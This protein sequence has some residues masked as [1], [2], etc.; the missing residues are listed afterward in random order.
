MEVVKEDGAYYLYYKLTAKPNAKTD[1]I[2]LTD[3][4]G[5][6]QTVTGNIEVKV[7]GQD[8]AHTLSVSDGGRVISG[9]ITPA[10]GI[11]ANKEVV[12]T[13]KVKL[14]QNEDGTPKLTD[15][16][17]HAEWQWDDK[18]WEDETEVTP[19]VPDP[20][21]GVNKTAPSS[22]K[23][24]EGIEY[25]VTI[26]NVEVEPDV[27]A[28]LHNYTFH[29]YISNYPFAFNGPVTVKDNKNIEVSGGSIVRPVKPDGA[30]PGE[31]F[32]LF[33]YTFPENSTAPYY[34]ITYTVTAMQET[35]RL[36]NLDVFSS[37]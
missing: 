23:P 10:G 29:D 7:D 26:H 28:D 36:T 37:T 20:A 13:Y 32:E 35:L 14:D 34:T 15:K 17:N 21:F 25:T 31:S 4:I 30:Q 3:T 2:H 16:T 22:V 19:E 33:N 1:S 18:P 9:D 8:A 5:E 6:G 12:V 27:Y 11:P 24:G